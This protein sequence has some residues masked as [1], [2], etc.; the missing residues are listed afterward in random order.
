LLAVG[1]A[2]RREGNWGEGAHARRKQRAFRNNLGPKST[3]GRPKRHHMSVS[4]PTSQVLD[5]LR[6]PH[7]EVAQKATQT[8][9]LG[10]L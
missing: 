10:R 2:G 6:A 3:V 8:A 4:S 1:S 5:G 9:P 7:D